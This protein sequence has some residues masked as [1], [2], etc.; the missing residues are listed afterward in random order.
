[1][2]SN[3]VSPGVLNNNFIKER[4]FEALLNEFIVL[5]VIYNIEYENKV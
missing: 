3:L 5:L 2:N 4:E 1:M